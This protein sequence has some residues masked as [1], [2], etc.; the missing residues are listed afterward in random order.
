MLRRTEDVVLAVE[1]ALRYCHPAEVSTIRTFQEAG[2]LT[3]E[4]GIVIRTETGEEFQV[5]IERTK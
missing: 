1:N 2:L 4:R 3:S 5:T